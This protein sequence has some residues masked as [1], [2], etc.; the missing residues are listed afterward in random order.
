LVSVCFQSVKAQ[1][2]GN[3]TINADGGISPSLAP[4]I[5]SGNLYSLTSDINGSISI[6]RNDCT[7]DGKGHIIEGLT[8]V[9]FPIDYAQ[10]LLND[11]SNDT[12]RNL[13]IIGGQFGIS[14][15]GLG[16]IIANNTVTSTG[17]SGIYSTQAS[18]YGIGVSG[19]SNVITGN[20]LLNKW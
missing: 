12:L 7:F 8:S 15:W 17:I 3:I 10:L 4:I 13:Q 14:I 20:S 2:Q 18:S 19:D 6:E 11:T 5:Q 9:N 1:Y 16:N